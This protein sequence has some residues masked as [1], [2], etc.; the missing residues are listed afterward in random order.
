MASH[1]QNCDSL[2]SLKLQLPFDTHRVCILIYTDMFVNSAEITR[3]IDS[4]TQPFLKPWY[5]DCL[6]HPDNALLL[7]MARALHSD[8]SKDIMSEIMNHHDSEAW[9][10][11]SSRCSCHELS[12]SKSLGSLD[13]EQYTTATACLIA[14]YSV[15]GNIRESEDDWHYPAVLLLLTVIEDLEECHYSNNLLGGAVSASENSEGDMEV[16]TSDANANTESLAH[17][18]QDL[19]VTADTIRM[20]DSRAAL[21]GS[22]EAQPEDMQAMV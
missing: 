18:M 17:A 4:V 12:M 6:L 11:H 13:F 10:G 16:D 15:R 2:Q 7:N 19:S 20:P 1:Q 5:D 8:F 22:D 3:W 21:S 9:S 14:R